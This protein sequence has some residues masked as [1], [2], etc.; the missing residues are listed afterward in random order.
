MQFNYIFASRNS[1]EKNFFGGI[2][3]LTKIKL[4]KLSANICEKSATFNYSQAVAF[5]QREVMVP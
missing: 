3:R 2:K 1:E 5:I 4:E